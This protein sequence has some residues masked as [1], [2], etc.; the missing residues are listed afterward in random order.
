MQG[1]VDISDN[2]LI[3]R[4]KFT[5]R[6]QKPSLVQREAIKRLMSAFAENRIEFAGGTVA[7]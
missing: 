5:V 1:V 3:V 4:F 7:A 2:A 6:P